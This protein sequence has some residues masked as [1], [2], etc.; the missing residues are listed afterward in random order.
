MDQVLGERDDVLRTVVP[1]DPQ[2]ELMGEHRAPV[3]L[4]APGC[5]AAAAYAELW[6]ELQASLR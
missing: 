4:F 3:A 1:E 2:V 6:V 5:P